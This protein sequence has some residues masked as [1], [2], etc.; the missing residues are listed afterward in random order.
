MNAVKTHDASFIAYS[1]FIYGEL[2]IE[3]QLS[4]INLLVGSHG[5]LDCGGGRGK[6]LYHQ[7]ISVVSFCKILMLWLCFA[8]NPAQIF[9]AFPFAIHAVLGM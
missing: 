5:L 2:T 9:S 1:P 8:G 3:N 7:K 4:L 6:F